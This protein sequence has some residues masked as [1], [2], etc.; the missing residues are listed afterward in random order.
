MLLCPWDSL[1]KDTGV[2]CH[3][4]CQGIFPTQGFNLPLL[5]LPALAGVFFTTGAT[6]EAQF[7]PAPQQSKGTE[8][9]LF[10]IT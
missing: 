5:H 9:F 10:H 2:G 6:Q 8:G 3:A 4:L 1:G 7:L